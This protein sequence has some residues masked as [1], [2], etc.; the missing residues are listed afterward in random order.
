MRNCRLGNE[1]VD[2]RKKLFGF[3]V[4]VSNQQTDFVLWNDVP[5]TARDGLRRLNKTRSILL[6]LLLVGRSPH[7]NVVRVDGSC[8]RLS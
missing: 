7:H 3:S 6:N 4:E 8:T 1:L 5:K 2:T